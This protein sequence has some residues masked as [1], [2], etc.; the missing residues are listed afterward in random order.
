MLHRSY[1][2]ATPNAPRLF[3]SRTGRSRDRRRSSGQGLAEFALVFP[4]FV[5]LVA[6]M[7]D[8]GMGLYSY[9]TVNNATRVGTRLAVTAC[10]ALPEGCEGAVRASVVNVSNG[11]ITG[12]DVKSPAPTRTR[13]PSPVPRATA[14]LC[15]AR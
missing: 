10:T 15:Q 8:F 9:M 7:V 5:L 14:R 12:S 1:A 6:A 4:I 11:L 2:S 13:R 3:G